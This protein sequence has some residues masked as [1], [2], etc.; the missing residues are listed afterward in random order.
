MAEVLPGISHGY[1]EEGKPYGEGVKNT[2]E[3]GVPGNLNRTNRSSSDEEEGREKI[4]EGLKEKLVGPRKGG[5]DVYQEQEGKD[6]WDDVYQEKEEKEWEDDVYQE[7]RVKKWVYGQRKEGEDMHQEKWFTG[8][9]K[10]WE[11]MHPEN[12][13]K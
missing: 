1:V 11:D 13:E 2:H 3:V 12:Q 9:E 4:K 10:E 8:L 6:W 7:D 5:E